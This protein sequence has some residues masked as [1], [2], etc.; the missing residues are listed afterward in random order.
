META[1]NKDKSLIHE[2]LPDNNLAAHVVQKK[3]DYSKIRNQ[4][5]KI[6]KR[7][8]YY[9][10]GAAMAM[11]NRGSCGFMGQDRREIVDLGYNT[12]AYSNT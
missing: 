12:G 3:G 10:H 9:D 11:E 8:F 2:D 6:I 1:L 7:R 5:F 4:A